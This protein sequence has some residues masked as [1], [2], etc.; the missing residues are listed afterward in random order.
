MIIKTIILC[1]VYIGYGRT[2]LLLSH[3]SDTELLEAAF[4]GTPVICVPRDLHEERNADRAA[5]WKFSM[6]LD[7][8]FT[9]DELV[10]LVGVLHET[11]DYRES[12]RKVSMG[13]RDRPS[14][15][16]DRLTFWLSYVARNNYEGM[17]FL[18][19]KRNVRGLTEEA[20]FFEGAVTGFVLG[21]I[22]AI[23]SFV[24]RFI[25]MLNA[26]NTQRKLKAEY[27]R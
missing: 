13:I 27:S 9:S 2:R 18:S 4:H 10:E 26:E 7:S 23:C 21:V 6:T 17:R 16:S 15:A 20:R 1:G 24:V 25:L 22:V 11:T 19:A 5:E 14:P 3:C 12:A 8:R